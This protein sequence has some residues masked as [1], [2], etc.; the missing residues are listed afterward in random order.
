MK[1]FVLCT[2]SMCAAILVFAL[3]SSTML[4]ADFDNRSFHLPKDG[5]HLTALTNL[6]FLKNCTN[7]LK[8]VF[9]SFVVWRW[10]RW[11]CAADNRCRSGWCCAPCKIIW[12]EGNHFYC[13]R[14]LFILLQVGLRVTCSIHLT[15]L[16]VHHQVLKLHIEDPGL[17]TEV[18]KPLQELAVAPPPQRSGISPVH[19]GLMAG[20]AA[21]SGAAVMVYLKRSQLWFPEPRRI[22]AFFFPL[23]FLFRRA[24]CGIPK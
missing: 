2:S 10:W 16:N 18:T 3:S 22:H 19:V 1:N 4:Q 17:N 13:L 20:V 12:I 9:L 7:Q 24:G 11:P 14:S 15:K 23:P 8:M 5:L 6:F 21:L